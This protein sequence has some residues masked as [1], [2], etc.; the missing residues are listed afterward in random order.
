MT[1]I[2]SPKK[3]SGCGICSRVCPVTNVT[4]IDKD[5]PIFGEHCESCFACVHNCPKKAI[6]LK[7][8]KSGERFRNP[9]VSTK[10]IIAA[11]QQ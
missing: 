7:N 9:N 10:E 11:N 3:I 1:A 5:K 4:Q 8:E 6:H 2:T